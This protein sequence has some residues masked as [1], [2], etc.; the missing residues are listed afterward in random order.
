MHLKIFK[1]SLIF[2]QKKTNSL[3]CTFQKIWVLDTICNVLTVCSISTHV[4]CHF[5][6]QLQSE[7]KHCIQS[8]GQKN[9]HTF[10]LRHCSHSVWKSPKKISKI[11]P[12]RESRTLVTAS[13]WLSNLGHFC[14]SWT[15]LL[16]RTFVKFKFS[17]F[18]KI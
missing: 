7:R 1:K 15:M 13:Q 10:H 11:H 14:V 8:H 5:I 18:D 12:R 6:F 4:F 16:S 2:T 3:F 17:T 9:L